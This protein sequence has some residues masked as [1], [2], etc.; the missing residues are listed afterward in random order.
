MEFDKD[1]NACVKTLR[2]GGII[3]YPTDTIWGIGCDATNPEAVKKLYEIKQR[4]ESKSLIVLVDSLSMLERYVQDLPE[5]AGQLTEVADT[6]LTIVYP[7]GKNMA[8]GVAASDGS[9]GIRVCNEQF[10]SA[11]IG[12]FRK[13]IVSTSANFSGQPS[14]QC[15]DDIDKQLIEKADYTVEYRQNDLSKAKASSIIKIEA[16][17]TFK[18]IRK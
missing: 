8:D 1:V 6:P 9:V 7:K 10:C 2:E 17:G 15:F 11:L 18:I 5:I 14:P 3:I 16:N 12:R 4:D 13:P